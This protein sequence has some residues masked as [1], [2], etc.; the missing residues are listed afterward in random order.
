MCVY[1][2][3]CIMYSIRLLTLGSASYRLVSVTLMMIC[4]DWNML[5]IYEIKTDTCFVIVLMYDVNEISGFGTW[6]L[7]RHLV[8]FFIT[9]V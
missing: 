3:D 5:E 6:N 8:L 1:F 7:V 2:C 4:T 9:C